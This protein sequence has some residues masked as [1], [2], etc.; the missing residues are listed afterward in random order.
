MEDID[1]DDLIKD[2]DK[3]YEDFYWFYVQ[4]KYDIYLSQFSPA[5]LSGCSW[6][7]ILGDD[8]K[9]GYFRYILNNKTT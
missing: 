7:Q 5:Y 4:F 8:F 9:K 6:Y 1:L 2:V 3:V